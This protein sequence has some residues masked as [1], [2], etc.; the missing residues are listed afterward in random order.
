M[1]GL[2]RGRSL[3]PDPQPVH[4]VAEADI[5]AVKPY[6]SCQVWALVQ[7]QLFTAAR[8][9]ELVTLRP[10]DLDGSGRIRTYKP[11]RHKTVH[12]GHRRT[13]CFGPRARRSSSRFFMNA[14]RGSPACR[15]VRQK[16]S[17]AKNSTSGA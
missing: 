11:D 5:E 1:E 4:P 6:V 3:A 8:S 7:L 2:R 14:C 9:G 12:R 10:A 13:I 15:R 17:V 16:S